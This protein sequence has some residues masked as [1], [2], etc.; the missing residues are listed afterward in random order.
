M[1]RIDWQPR[2]W[3]EDHNR[4]PVSS[5]EGLFSKA[6]AD[7][8]N[9]RKIWEVEMKVWEWIWRGLW[10]KKNKES[11]V[12]FVFWLTVC[13]GVLVTRTQPKEK[14]VQAGWVHRRL[15]DIQ[16]K[17]FSD[18]SLEVRSKIQARDTAL[19]VPMSGGNHECN[20]DSPG[21]DI[22]WIAQVHYFPVC[23]AMYVHH[24]GMEL[25]GCSLSIIIIGARKKSLE[26]S[27]ME[28][29]LILSNYHFSGIEFFSTEG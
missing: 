20:W 25:I 19:V 7:G 27:R 9:L 29:N 24:I 28:K 12:I 10:G 3:L 16:G 6:V 23:T 2:G 4:N 5:D 13:T 11:E 22:E 14:V 15:W 21:E 1:W 18:L 26:E 17:L 8:V